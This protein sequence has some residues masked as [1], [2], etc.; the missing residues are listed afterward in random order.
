MCAEIVNSFAANPGQTIGLVLGLGGIVAVMV[1]TWTICRAAVRCTAQ[2]EQT[3][4]EIAAYVAEGSLSPEDAERIIQPSPWWAKH[5]GG[6]FN[7]V[8]RNG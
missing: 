5:C 3:R 6:V 8:R 2:R 4:R 7:A 1:I